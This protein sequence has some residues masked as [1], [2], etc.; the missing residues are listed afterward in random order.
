MIP[1]KVPPI[2]QPPLK[3]NSTEFEKKIVKLQEEQ[4]LAESKIQVHNVLLK[5]LYS[6]IQEGIIP[7]LE[8]FCSEAASEKTQ[9]SCAPQIKRL[10]NRADKSFEIYKKLQ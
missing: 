2:E 10:L 8:L 5:E 3:S 4:R 6:L 7:T 1:N 9:R